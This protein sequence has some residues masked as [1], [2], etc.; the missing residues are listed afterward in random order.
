[1]PP[2]PLAL[3]E[4]CPVETSDECFSANNLL[5]VPAV[6]SE[7]DLLVPDDPVLSVTEMGPAAK[8]PVLT[9]VL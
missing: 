7:F 5:F 4:E 6:T 1:L 8:D 2:V 9:E 3:A